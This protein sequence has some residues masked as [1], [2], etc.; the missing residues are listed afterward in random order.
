[1]RISVGRD[2]NARYVLE[3]GSAFGVDVPPAI[4]MRDV[5]SLDCR[6]GPGTVVCMDGACPAQAI[7]PAASAMTE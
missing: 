5:E 2:A 4:G 6:A 3:N 7:S 1:L